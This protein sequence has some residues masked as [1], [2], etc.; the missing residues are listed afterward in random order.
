MVSCFCSTY[1]HPLLW[2][3]YADQHKGVCFEIGGSYLYE[4]ARGCKKTLN[5]NA[6][7]QLTEFNSVKYRSSPPDESHFDEITLK[8]SIFIKS[9]FFS[10]EQEKRLVIGDSCEQI[11]RKDSIYYIPFNYS[12]SL[13]SVT[14]G[15]RTILEEILKFKALLDKHEME[16][17]KLYKMH[18]IHGTYTLSRVALDLY[19]E[20]GIY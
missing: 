17:V 18:L 12:K 15:I 1:D 8:R 4:I 11:E 10:Y 13:I 14:F 6:I 3:H 20:I 7:N 5:K 9:L 19:K 16:N 2:T